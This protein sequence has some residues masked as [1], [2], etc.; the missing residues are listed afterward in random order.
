M[1]FRALS[2][3]RRSDFFSAFLFYCGTF[4]IPIRDETVQV[5]VAKFISIFLICKG[6]KIEIERQ[7]K[8][9]K[10]NKSKE[11]LMVTRMRF[12]NDG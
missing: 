10:R 7:T 5:R 11:F 6:T 4:K 9:R 1:K 8:N 3:D 12:I 2:I